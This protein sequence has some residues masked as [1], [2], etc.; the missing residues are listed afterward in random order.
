MG[1]EA[2]AACIKKLNGESRGKVGPSCVFTI[3]TAHTTQLLAGCCDKAGGSSGTA[4]PDPQGVRSH[5]ESSGYGL[6]VLFRQFLSATHHRL[7][8]RHKQWGVF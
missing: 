3:I 8:Q 7:E 1:T 2:T 5:G 6:P 4:R